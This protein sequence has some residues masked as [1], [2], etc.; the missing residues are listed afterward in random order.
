MTRSRRNIIL[1]SG[2]AMLLIAGILC[3]IFLPRAAAKKEMRI[4]LERAAAGNVQYLVLTDPHYKSDELFANKGKEITLSG[5]VLQAARE[6]LLQLSSSLKYKGSDKESITGLDL[7]LFA[8]CADGSYV[9]IYF[10]SERFYIISEDTTYYFA[11]QTDH[12]AAL[13]ATLQGALQ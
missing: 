13:L 3:G 1:C 2:V 12:Y 10:Q 11:A 5:E 4:A 8:R 7:Q 9:Q 6:Q